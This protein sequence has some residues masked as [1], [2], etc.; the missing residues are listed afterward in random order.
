MAD[1]PTP[2][3]DSAPLPEPDEE[4]R[5][6]DGAAAPGGE[7]PPESEEARRDRLTDLERAVLDLESATWRYG[8]AK[9]HAIR[10]R[11]GLTPTAYY[12]VL[13]GLLDRQAALAYR[14]LLVSR[15]LR[16]RGTRR[17]ASRTPPAPPSAAPASQ[18]N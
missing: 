10:E 8:G 2:A 9:D 17:R 18:E 1:M 6:D 5:P 4:P 12:Q 14:P 15:L 11:L 3:A 7:A 13:N 16:S